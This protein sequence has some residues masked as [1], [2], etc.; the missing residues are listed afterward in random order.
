[1]SDIIYVENE[2]NGM[3]VLIND[4]EQEVT[5]EGL[6][7]VRNGQDEIKA[8]V[9]DIVK[10]D[11]DTYAEEQKTE[12]AEF[13]AQQTDAVKSELSANVATVQKPALDAYTEVK[14]TEL[15]AYE[16]SKE[17]ELGDYAATTINTMTSLKNA[18]ATSEANAASSAASAAASATGAANT[19]NG[20]DAHA[21]EKQ[22]AFDANATAQTQAANQ[23]I[24]EHK[25]GLVAEFDAHAAEKQSAVDASAAAAKTS[26]TNAKASEVACQDVLERLGTVIKIKGRVDGMDDLPSVGNLNGD[27]YLVGSAGLEEYAE[28]YWFENHWEFLG[29]TGTKL[30]WGI[31][32]GE[33]SAQA[34]LQSALNAQTS[35]L[36]AQ[37]S[38]LNTHTGNKSNPHGVTKAQVGLGNCD[39]TSDVNKPVS[40][41]VQNALNLKA[42]LA[43]PAFSGTPTVPTAA[44]STNNTQAVNTQWFN[45]K[46]QVVSALPSSP[47]SN[48]FYFIPE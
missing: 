29:T 39:N 40:T 48:V 6:I 9:A 12:A 14:K 27:A 13:M 30:A 23:A 25:A 42:N 24:S 2:L 3:E 46:I 16:Q 33:I 37:T 20:F 11:I 19:V 8:Y 28:Y 26:E 35:A 44:V 31:I 15:D 34:D 32:T 45:Q 47:N 17:G 38:A 1:M 10:P 7:F 18:A 22:S 36:S 43:S 5:P 41:A 4:I 21:A